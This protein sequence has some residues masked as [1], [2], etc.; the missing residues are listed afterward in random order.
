MKKVI[1]LYKT[2][3]DQEAFMRYYREKHVPLTGTIPGLAHISVT[4]IT[5]TLAGEQGNYLLAELQFEDEAALAAAMKT[6][7]F[8]ATGQDLGNFAK[9][10][11]TIMIGETF[12]P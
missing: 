12:E 2:P 11:A 6:P 4:R 3:E 1:A 7:E 8:A 10:I 5:K 9:G